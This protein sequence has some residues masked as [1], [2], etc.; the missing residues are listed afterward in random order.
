M[1]YKK[2][3]KDIVEHVGGKENVES[4]SHCMTR[5]RFNLK[6]PK[7]ANL[8]ELK[9]IEG[10]VGAVYSVGQC[11]VILGKNLMPVFSMVTQEYDFSVGDAVDENLDEELSDSKGKNTGT[12]TPDKR[13]TPRAVGKWIVEYVI[14]SVSPIIP[15][16]IAGGMLRVVLLIVSMTW[17]S[18]TE[19]QSYALFNMLAQIPFYFLPFLVTYGAA[20]KLGCTPIYPM[21]LVAS[22]FYPNFVALL[23]SGDPIAIFGLKVTSISYANSLVPAL[24]AAFTVA[25]ME[26]LFNKIIP[27]VL[28]SV[29]V[30]MFTL[31]ASYVLVIVALGPIG[32][33]IGNYLVA[34]L[35]WLRSTIGPFANAIVTMILPYMIMTGTHS[36]FGPVM[37]QTIATVGYD[38]FLRPSLLLHNIAQGGACFGVALRTKNRA[39]RSQ[40]ISIGLGCL[41]GVTEPAIF[42]ICLPLKRPLLGMAIGGG[43]GSFVAGLLGARNYS[44]G[45][46]S[47][48]AL[49]IFEDTIVAMIIGVVIALV[50]SAVATFILGFV[51]PV[52]TKNK[53]SEV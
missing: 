8:D 43:I 41:A 16:L 21:I 13:W 36:L 23:A 1:N 6:D 27:G 15:G 50:G 5:L 2:A 37:V 30:G 42:G 38:N 44:V 4:V 26:K 33:Y 10:V 28:K 20:K 52:E 18:V 48:F 47:I 14:G 22:L 35:V 24:L 53:I 11:Q 19:T 45:Y 49:P 9:K 17:P 34:A 7:L 39:L 40:A 12:G 46:S 25:Q 32:I 31:A 29:F 3:A 51:D